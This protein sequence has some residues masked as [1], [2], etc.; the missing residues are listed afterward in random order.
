MKGCDGTVT[1]HLPGRTKE[2]KSQS[3]YLF[4]SKMLSVSATHLITTF[5]RESSNMGISSSS[6]SYVSTYCRKAELLI[7]LKQIT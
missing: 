5:S 3:G 4:S 2:K 1:R 7:K 6:M